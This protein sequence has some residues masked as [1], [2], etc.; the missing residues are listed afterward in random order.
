MDEDIALWD[1]QIVAGYLLVF[2]N[3]AL[4]PVIWRLSKRGDFPTAI[5]YLFTFIASMFYHACRADFMCFYEYKMHRLADYIF[6]YQAISWTLTS[7]GLR[8]CDILHYRLHVFLFVLLFGL[9]IFIVIGGVS[10][11]I[12]PIFGIAMP[13]LITVLFSYHTGNRLFYSK[14]WTIVMYLTAITAGAFMFF[15]PRRYY[16]WAHTL[17]H[18]FAMLSAWAFDLAT[19]PDSIDSAQRRQEAT[20][21]KKLTAQRRLLIVQ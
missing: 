8:H 15:A 9:D 5:I 10:H 14:P 3:L 18:V 11:A 12:L 6:V 21:M 16:A 19:D 17:W 2:S 4:F 7:L 20:D 1:G 13:I